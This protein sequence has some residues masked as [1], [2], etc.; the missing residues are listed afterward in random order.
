MYIIANNKTKVT[1]E[2]SGIYKGGDP[3]DNMILS[4]HNIDPSWTVD[5]YSIFRYTDVNIYDKIKKKG[6]VYELVWSGETITGV[7]FDIP[8][9]KK[10]IDMKVDKDIV[11][12]DIDDIV[13]ITLTLYEHDETTIISSF[14]GD[15]T[16]K[17]LRPT[18]NQRGVEE[19]DVDF[20]FVN[21]VCIY[22][23]SEE[24]IGYW[25]IP[26]YQ[27]LSY[28]IDKEIIIQVVP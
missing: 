2:V 12:S 7:D 16:L 20:T 23:F 25:Y 17:M 11:S 28:R 15:I 4:I 21:G 6:F 3:D 13:V 24:L 10:Y 18:E 26:S 1:L 27:M 14:N 19:V 22:N 5:D 8:S 9:A